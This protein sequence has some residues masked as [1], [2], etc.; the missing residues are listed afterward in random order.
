MQTSVDELRNGVPRTYMAAPVTL[1]EPDVP[2][3]G[4]FATR[5]QH[6]VP[7]WGATQPRWCGAGALHF[8]CSSAIVFF[9]HSGDAGGSGGP[10]GQGA[11]STHDS[12]EPIGSAQLSS[13]KIKRPI[14]ELTE[15]VLHCGNKSRTLMG[16]YV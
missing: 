13:K 2:T 12:E 9:A 6:H 7:C 14:L 16:R 4:R 8:Y 5:R 1:G 11:G 10:P 3:S 15:E